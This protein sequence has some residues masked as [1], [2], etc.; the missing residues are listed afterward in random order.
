MR[1]IG[2]P[3]LALTT[4]ASL[5]GHFYYFFASLQTRMNLDVVSVSGELRP[6]QWWTDLASE[7]PVLCALKKNNYE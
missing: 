2:E 6:S 3:S 5:W 7:R 4:G 1:F